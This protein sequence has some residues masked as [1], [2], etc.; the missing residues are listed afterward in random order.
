MN[1]ARKSHLDRLRRVPGQATASYR[2]LAKIASMVDEATL[3]AGTLLTR[4]GARHRQTFLILDGH[5]DVIIDG[6]VVGGAGPGDYVGEMGMLVHGPQ[7]ATV[8]ATGPVEVL[9]IGAQAFWTFLSQDGVSR[10]LATQ[11]AGRLRG[12]DD[13]V[14][15]PLP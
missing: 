3:P 12:I 14:I 5:A 9:V 2:Q 1:T 11:L 8:R 4:Q 6:I 7:R 15:A 13:R 10:A